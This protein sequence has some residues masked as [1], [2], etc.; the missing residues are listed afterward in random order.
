[1]KETN[2]H[3]GA[4]DLLIEDLVSHGLQDNAGDVNAHQAEGEVLESKGN[5]IGV[6]LI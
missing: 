4:N 6:G 1:M 2:R 5:F 3:N